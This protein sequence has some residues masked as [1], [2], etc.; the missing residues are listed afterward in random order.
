M[1]E[2]FNDLLSFLFLAFIILAS[3]FYAFSIFSTHHAIKISQ[4][5]DEYYNFIDEDD[6]EN[7]DY[8]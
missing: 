8:S 2:N 5:E 1:V 6:I 3:L 4:L 7:D